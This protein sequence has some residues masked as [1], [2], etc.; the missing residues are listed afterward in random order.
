[1]EN[2]TYELKTIEQITDVVNEENLKGFLL[3]FEGWLRFGIKTKSNKIFKPDLKTFKWN[4]DN[5]WGNL[6]EI[7]FKIKL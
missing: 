7:V 1:M 4:D 2:K 6:R 3:D 5:D